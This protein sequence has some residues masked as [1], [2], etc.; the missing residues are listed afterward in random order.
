M[1]VVRRTAGRTVGG[2]GE[3]GDTGSGGKIAVSR[4]DGGEDGDGKISEKNCGDG[5][6]DGDGGGGV[7]GMETAA[8]AEW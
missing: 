1:V 8:M 6:G 7:V 2:R 4:G 5:R 3:D